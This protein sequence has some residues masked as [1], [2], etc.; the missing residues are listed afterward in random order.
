MGV[1]VRLI[2]VSNRLDADLFD[3]LDRSQRLIVTRLDALRTGDEDLLDR[4]LNRRCAIISVGLGLMTGI[5]LAAGLWS[6][7]CFVDEPATLR[8][9]SPG[10]GAADVVAG[11]IRRVG[12][13]SLAVLL[14]ETDEVDA[15]R[16]EL[17]GAIDGV[18]PGG[19]EPL[20]WVRDWIGRRSVPAM[21]SGAALLRRRGGDVTE[22]AEFSRLFATGEPQRGLAGFLDKRL[23]DFSDV[24]VIDSR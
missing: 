4:W 21:L 16:A 6:D 10:P 15:R 11:L 13:H 24:V 5:G 2:F 7:L 20:D 12:R 22:R 1:S 18:T 17:M 3:S 19:V 14:E 9:R 23:P 8:F